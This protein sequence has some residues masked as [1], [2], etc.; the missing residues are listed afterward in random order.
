M[1]KSILLTLI[2]IISLTSIFAKSAKVQL[3]TNVEETNVLYNLYYG[4]EKIEDNNTPYVISVA[5]LTS[6]GETDSFS[7]YASGNKNSDMIVNVEIN[8]EYFKTTINGNSEYVTDIKPSVNTTVEKNIFPA[9][10]NTNYLVNQFF[11]S[12]IGDSDLPA[13]DYK[14]DVKIEYSIQ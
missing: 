14:S 13:G 7:V 2:S 6:N 10:N 3:V 8:S 12:W 5:P 11:L 9:G 1:K 4:S